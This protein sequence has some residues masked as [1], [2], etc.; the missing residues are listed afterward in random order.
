MH[1]CPTSPRGVM[2][3]YERTSATIGCFRMREHH[4][5]TRVRFAHVEMPSLSEVGLCTCGD[6]LPLQAGAVRML[7]HTPAKRGLSRWVNTYCA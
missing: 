2:Y 7:E 4:S 3:M 1:R 6:D 5:T